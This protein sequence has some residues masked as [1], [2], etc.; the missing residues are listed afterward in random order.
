MGRRLHHP[1]RDRDVRLPAD[2]DRLPER[3]LPQGQEPPR[4]RQRVA[5]VRGVPQPV[6][7]RATAGGQGQG[8][9]PRG[10]APGQHGQAAHLQQRHVRPQG[11]LRDAHGGGGGGQGHGGLHPGPPRDGPQ[12]GRGAGPERVRLP[13][14][15]RFGGGRRGVPDLGQPHARELRR[16]VRGRQADG[17]GGRGGD[18]VRA[19]HRGAQGREGLHHPQHLPAALQVEAHGRGGPREGVHRLRVG[20]RARRAHG[21]PHHRH[22]RRAGEERLREEAQPR[23]HRRGRA[24]GRGADGGDPALRGG[25]QDR[26]GRQVPRAG[27]GLQRPG[28]RGGQGGGPRAQGDQPVQQRQ[29]PRGLRLQCQDPRHARA[30]HHQPERGHDPA[31]R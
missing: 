11:H 23:D 27:E 22:L 4:L 21:A 8:G 20:G 25:V 3:V 19:A 29:V 31:G 30:V 2:L 13:A 24:A 15:D 12:G 6:R 18:Q 14:R 16:D 5:A 9:A 17:G 28:L 10:R 1:A 26:G 7:V